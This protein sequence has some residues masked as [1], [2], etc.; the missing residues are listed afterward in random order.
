MSQWQLLPGSAL[1]CSP[2]NCYV[3]MQGKAGAFTGINASDQ[4]CDNSDR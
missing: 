1:P 4:H 2:S 3:V